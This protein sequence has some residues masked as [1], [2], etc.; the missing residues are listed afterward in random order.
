MWR[1]AGL[2]YGADLGALRF[3]DLVPARP[4]ASVNSTDS[5]GFVAEEIKSLSVRGA[6]FPLQSG[7][8][9][10]NLPVGA[11]GDVVLLEVPA[12]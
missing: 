5:F 10:D 3:L 8:H 1:Q 11:T 2:L 4:A 9:N 7:P 12:Y 6:K